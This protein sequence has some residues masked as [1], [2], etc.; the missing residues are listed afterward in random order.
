M[1]KNYIYQIDVRN[2]IENKLGKELMIPVYG[3]SKDDAW[4]I[5]IQSY[6]TSPDNVEEELKTDTYNARFGMPG[7][8][9]YGSWESD[10]KIYSAW[11]NNYGQEPFV[12]E[13][14]YNGLAPTSIEIVEE[15]RLLFNLYYNSQKNEYIDVENDGV[16]VIRTTDT[17]FICVH[18]RYLKTYLALKNKVMLIHVDSRCVNMDNSKKIAEDGLAYYNPEGTLFYTLNIGNARMSLK[19]ENYSFIYAKKVVAGCE[20]Q[21]CN[22]WPY[23]QEK[24]YI[25]FILGVD[26]NGKEIK[27]TCDPDKLSNY[28]GA[29]PSAPHYLTPVYFDAAVLHKYYSKPEIYKVE[30]GIIRCGNLWA[31][32]IDNHNPG[33]V[34]AYLG[35]LGRNLPSEQEQHYWR[36]FNKSIDGELSET[37]FYRDFLSIPT[38][39]KSPDFVFKKTYATV[40]SKFMEK[41]GWP[42]FLD[43]DEQ[44]LY[45]FE[46]LRIPINN[47]IVEMDMLVLSLVKVLLD[48]LNEKN[49]VKQLTGTYEKLVGSISK[50]EMWFSEKSLAD[51]QDQI[52]F[53]RNLQELR[54][55]G[56]GH[57][58]GKGYQKIS[59][60]F[61]IQQ[62]NYAETFSSILNDATDFL[63]YIESNIDALS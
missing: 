36:G 49:I 7:I 34:S 18:K 9:V 37:K 13:R 2:W 27:Y 8:T 52:K 50:L 6:L 30:D 17:G 1:D 25:D 15:F 53:L 32:Y 24:S 28:F 40:N 16:T 62:E 61:N 59:K 58:K 55:T 57:R 19:E 41:F 29:N 26:E 10:E 42:I 38:D 44:D 31:L 63:R 14:D 60:T 51:Y 5:C 21:N 11:N 43:L 33:Y 4:D 48:S 46:S 12:I 39:S 47:S 3:T 56:T 22:I 23:N 35:D 20:L 54:S 45:N